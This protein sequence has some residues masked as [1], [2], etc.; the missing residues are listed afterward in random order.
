MSPCV[1]SVDPIVNINSIQCGVCDASSRD[2]VR[3]PWHSHAMS[4]STELPARPGR[5]AIAGGGASGALVATNLLRLG[6]AGLEVVVIEPRAELGLGVAYATR[7]PWHRLNVPALSMSAFADDLDHFRRWMDVP[8]EAFPRRLDYGRYLQAVFADAVATSGAVLRHVRATVERLAPDGDGVALGLSTGDTLA[9]DALVL[10]TGLETA[11]PPRLPRPAHRRSAGGARPLG[12][13]RPRHGGR[14]GRR[15]RDRQQ[16]DGDRRHGLDPQRAP[17]GD[18]HGPVAPRRPAASP[19]GPVATPPPATGV[20]RRGVPGNGLAARRRRRADPLLRRRMAPGRGLAAPDRPGAVDGDGRRPETRRSSPTIDTCGTSTATAS[21]PRS[22][23]TSSAGS[24]K[25]GSPC[26]GPPS[27]RIEPDGGRLRIIAE[28]PAAAWTADRIVV[29]VGPEPDATANPLLGA[30]IRDGLVAVGADGDRDRRAIRRPAACSTRTASRRCRPTRWARCARASC[31][32]RW[33]SRRSA[34]R[35]R[36]SRAGCWPFR[37]PRDAPAPRA[38]CQAF[39]FSSSCW[40][41]GGNCSLTPSASEID[42]RTSRSAAR[43][44]ISAVL[45]PPADPG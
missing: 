21:R 37:H 25:A 26:T 4:W 29:A 43:T 6:G 40:T 16:P 22:G 39:G 28:G 41:R 1:P 11:A 15:R 45:S 44:A 17:A 23:E 30:A 5:I 13:R 18:G 9:A 31:G 38:Q 3:R 20:H 32:R 10:A 7:D 19:R 2:R 14:R 12:G 24:P 33:R 35:P 42:S 8:G 27:E 34:T 36:T